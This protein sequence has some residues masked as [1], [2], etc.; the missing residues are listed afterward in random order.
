LDGVVTLTVPG[1]KI[2]QTGDTKIT[3]PTT[4][5]AIPYYT[6]NNR[7][8][9]NMLVWMPSQEDKV[10]PK[11]A[12]SIL[13]S[14]EVKA[15]TDWAPGLNDGF[16]PKNSS[17]TDKSYF[18][19]WLK[20]GS[21]DWVEYDFKKAVTISESSVYWLNMDHYDVDYRVPE[22]WNLQFLAPDN[23]WKAVETADV[24]K[25]TLDQY[26]SIRFKPVKTKAIRLNAKQQKGFSAGIL[27]W[28]V[29]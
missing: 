3:E 16:D 6:W 10:V 26:N 7:G 11:P 28:K 24:Y 9:S 17:D 2:T 29:N 27:E 19:W 13:D 8:K 21:E 25:T 22:S 14:A 18:Y 4:L 5:K 20:E 15:S 12:P 23:K 1:S